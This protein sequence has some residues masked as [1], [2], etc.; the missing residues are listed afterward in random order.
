VTRGLKTPIVLTQCTI[1]EW[2]AD[3]AVDLARHANDTGV[4]ANLRDAFPNPYTVDD[5]NIFLARVINDQPMT[6]FCLDIGASAAGGIGLR[7]GSDIYRRTAEFGY[8]L[9]RAYW[10][11]GI[12][13][14]AVG[15]FSDAAFE[16]F[17]LRRLYAE[18]FANNTASVRVLEKAG[19]ILEARLKNNVMKAGQLL[20]SFIY[21]KTC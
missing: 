21:A 8:W 10:N 11:R 12:M 9:G 17:D 16:A 13:S 6:N 14:E 2:R 4:A 5:A 19:F 7:L 1:R 15:A 18:P 3:D 20:D